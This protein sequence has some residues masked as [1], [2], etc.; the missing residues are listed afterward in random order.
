MDTNGKRPVLDGSRAS[1]ESVLVALKTQNTERVENSVV[2]GEYGVFT[3]I[4][5]VALMR[6]I[7]S[8]GVNCTKSVFLGLALVLEIKIRPPQEDKRNRLS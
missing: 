2:P 8:I 5:L 1:L 4:E 7:T 6:T 3:N